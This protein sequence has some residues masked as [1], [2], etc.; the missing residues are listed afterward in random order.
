MDGVD[1]MDGVGEAKKRKFTVLSEEAGLRLDVW[2][3]RHLPDFSRSAVQH[4]V[5]AGRVRL[6]GRVQTK[7][8]E[9]VRAGDRADIELPP[10]APATPQPQ[11]IALDIV[12]EDE[13]LLVLNKPAGLV[14][15]PAA[16]VRDGTL[17][18]ALLYHCRDLSGVGGVERPG[19]VHRLDKLTSGLMVVAKSDWVHRSLAAQLSSHSIRR[20]YAA[21]V[22]GTFQPPDGTISS[23][24][25]RHPSDRKRMAVVSVGGRRAVTHYRTVCTAGG[26]SVAELS[27]ET[28]RTHQIRVH[29]S[30][31]GHPVVGDAQYGY[32][33]KALEVALGRLDPALRAVTASA[34]RQLLHARRLQFAHPR[35][36]AL[37]DFEAPLPDDVAQVAAAIERLAA[38]AL[39]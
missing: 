14:V 2:L 16:G 29:L 3:A 12:Y 10:P 8:G 15:H 27:L 34:G 33:G 9:A 24:I 7:C 32:T 11:D 28:G 37:M 39:S 36:H 4:L 5:R 20:T 1:G 30:H 22:W 25:G 19:I 23:N 31:K 18:N 38:R 35:T 26:L 17:V 21:V 13:S 6:N